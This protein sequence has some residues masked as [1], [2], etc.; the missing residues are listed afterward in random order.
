[1]DVS[2]P[3]HLMR[4]WTTPTTKDVSGAAVFWRVLGAV[5]GDGLTGDTLEFMSLRPKVLRTD[6]RGLWGVRMGA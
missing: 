1:M 2:R 6:E 4:P 5:G 3:P